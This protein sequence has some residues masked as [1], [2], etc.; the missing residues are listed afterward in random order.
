MARISSHLLQQI[1]RHIAGVPASPED[2]AIVASQL[3]PNLDGL[4]RLD[5]L[6]LLGVEP[7]TIVPPPSPEPRTHG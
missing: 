4:V 2:L 1:G 3:A 7:A 6:E 5:D